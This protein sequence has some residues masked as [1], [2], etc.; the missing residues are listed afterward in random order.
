MMQTLHNEQTTRKREEF[1]L[2]FFLICLLL[3]PQK[4]LIHQNHAYK[5]SPQQRAIRNWNA[6]SMLQ[7]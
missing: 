5:K 6:L 1:P 3:N 7:E 4:I 2:S